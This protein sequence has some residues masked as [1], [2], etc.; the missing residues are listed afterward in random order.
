MLKAVFFDLDGT[1]L[2]I[3]EKSFS[4]LYFK[5]LGAKLE[6]YGYEKER[7]P[8]LFYQ[9]MA[10]MMYNDGTR[11]NEEAFFSFFKVIYPQAEEDIPIFNSF[12]T[13]EFKQIAAICEKTPLS[14][15][16]VDFVKEKGL[17]PVL[18]TNPIFPLVAQRTR[19]EIAGI[20]PDDFAYITGYEDSYYC[21]PNPMYFKALLEKFNLKSDEVIVFGNNDFEDGDCASALGLKVYLIDG[22]LIHSSHAKGKYETIEL[23]Q[24]IPTIEKEIE[25]RKTQTD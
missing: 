15:E 18:S 19:S 24:V 23:N 14:K 6:P 5:L 1:L 9:G 13:N 22:Y 25:K 21:K 8:K 7:L 12:Y 10:Q 3:D 4:E 16:I 2:R 11:N 20:N 17:I